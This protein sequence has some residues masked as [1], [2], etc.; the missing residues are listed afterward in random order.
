MKIMLVLTILLIGS[1][2]TQKKTQDVYTDDNNYFDYQYYFDSDFSQLDEFEQSA[3][4]G[5][6]PVLLQE[7]RPRDGDD[8]FFEDY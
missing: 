7:A 6:P 5:P 3:S 4:P 2:A 1:C 8:W